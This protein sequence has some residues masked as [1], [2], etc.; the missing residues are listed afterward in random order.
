MDAFSRLRLNLTQR[1]D[2]LEAKT[3]EV[4][5]GRVVSLSPLTVRLSDGFELVDV[6]SLEPN[7][8]LNDQ[9]RLLAHGGFRL[10]RRVLL[11]GRVASQV[12]SARVSPGADLNGYIIPGEYYIK[13][14]AD[15]ATISNTPT[16]TPGSLVVLASVGTVQLFYEY[17]AAPNDRVWRRR[18]YNG[19]WYAWALYSDSGYATVK[20]NASSAVSRL[21]TIDAG[22]TEY[23]PVWYNTNSS[24]LSIGN[25][26]IIGKYK[27][28]GKTCYFMISMVRGSTT[29]L[30][31]GYY[32]WTLPMNAAVWNELSGSGYIS[33]TTDKAVT[34]RPISTG[35][36]ALV[37]DVDRIGTNNPG[38]WA[39][40][41]GIFFTGFY[42]IP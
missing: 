11:V 33:H 19:N 1:M 17:D 24:V 3:P 8:E 37:N 27:V 10:G 2:A 12:V 34:V 7:L 41:H 36:V 25:G 4:L 38:S 13:S 29:N 18:F 16:G 39:A 30:G 23:T 9:V 28:I 31:S 42:P 21:D 15:I 35:R 5:Y 40:G 20:S 6:P 14:Y 26:S 32:T 22:W